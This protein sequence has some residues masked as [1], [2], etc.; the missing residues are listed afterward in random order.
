[1]IAPRPPRLGVLAA[2]GG[3]LL[4]T[5][6]AGGSDAPASGDEDT[7]ITISNPANVSNVALHVAIAQGFF[8]EEGLT[9]EADIDL[10]AG[11]TVEAVAGGQ[12]DMAWTN[13]VGGLTAY[14]EGIDIRLVAVT[15]V[16]VAGSQQ[17]LVPEDSD[18]E[19]VADLRGET[20]AVLSPATICIL[21]LRSALAAEGLPVDAIEVT[22]VSPPEHP[23]VLEAGE[24]AAT[25]T[26]DPFRTLMINELGARSVYDTS[27]GEL[28]GYAVGGYVV[29]EEFAQE[30]AGA[31]AAF[32]RALMR[33]TAYANSNPEEV[34]TELPEF[35][36]V[37]AEIADEVIINIFMEAA[38]V[39]AIEPEVQ[40]IADAM[41]E[42]GM[43]DEP[44]DIGD[45]IV[46]DG[47]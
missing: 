29:S 30:N 21:N 27:S 10:G 1:M 8:E 20:V 11:S 15:D 42:Y 23:N 9:V 28:E 14:N 22:P 46:P 43:V 44:I 16:A 37:D 7:T 26:S 31:L 4:T 25:C 34:R 38:D 41:L 17:V 2:A 39:A 36:T 12:V 45:Y 5:A 13:V 6:C 33:G 19:S 18:A 3:L 32:R 47:E 35:T 40:R 24:V